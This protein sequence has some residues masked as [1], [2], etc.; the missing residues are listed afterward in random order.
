[1]ASK[2]VRTKS[3]IKCVTS[4]VNLSHQVFT[5]VFNAETSYCSDLITV[6]YIIAS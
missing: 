3:V 1:M 6:C 4:K 2:M 5:H